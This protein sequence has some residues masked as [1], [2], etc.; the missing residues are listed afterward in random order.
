MTTAGIRVTIPNREELDA[1]HPCSFKAIYYAS[2]V[3]PIKDALRAVGVEPEPAGRAERG[4]TLRFEFP[5]GKRV[6][7][8]VD[9][10][11]Q[12][13]VDGLVKFAR[14]DFDFV[15]KMKP[16][17]RFEHEY[18]ANPERIYPWGY[19][20][21]PANTGEPEDC[22]AERH[23][24]FNQAL[25]HG[26]GEPHDDSL[27]YV[28]ECVQKYPDTAARHLVTRG[29][30]HAMHHCERRRLFFDDSLFQG[31]KSEMAYRE[32]IRDVARSE[33]MLNLC[34]PDVTIDRKVVEACAIGVPIVSDDGL[35]DLI[36]PWGRRFVHGE[37]VWFVEN[38][39]QVKQIAKE[40][41]PAETRA[42]LSAGGIALYDACFAPVA[43][44]QWM[45]KCV[46]QEVARP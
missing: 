27:R 31:E 5:D 42:R 32:H 41:L 36:L 20:I 2:Y 34:G 22:N 4:I 21:A 3:E 35:R 11:D 18:V 19:L 9:Y 44:G 16:C 45:L 24:F 46:L 37:N 29:S 6:A 15:F 38:L 30:Y 25:C 23:W 14:G 28:Q 33:A 7:A 8:I 1:A 12:V 13:H 17:D 26:W 40:G 10:A 43:I 39:Q